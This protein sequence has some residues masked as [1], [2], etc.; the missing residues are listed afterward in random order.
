[1]N[2]YLYQMKRDWIKGKSPRQI[3]IDQE[4]IDKEVVINDGWLFEREKLI[5][6]IEDKGWWMMI[7][8]KWWRIFYGGIGQNWLNSKKILFGN[9]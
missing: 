1:M 9:L 4:I 5:K 8:R 7:W 3:V 2:Q 6:V